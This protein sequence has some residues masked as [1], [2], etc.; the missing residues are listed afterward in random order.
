MAIIPDDD[1]RIF[2]TS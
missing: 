1:A 2:A